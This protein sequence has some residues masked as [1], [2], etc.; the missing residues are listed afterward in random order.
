[1]EPKILING[2]EINDL[3]ELPESVRNLLADGNNNQIPD[4]AENPFAMFSK[5]GD[6]K[7]LTQNMGPILQ[8]LQGLQGGKMPQQQ[9]TFNGKEY[10]NWNEI[11]ESE[12]QAIKAKFQQM[13]HLTPT[14]V[15]QAQ[16]ETVSQAAQ[17][18]S[19]GTPQR[20]TSEIPGTTSPAIQEK[21]DKNRIAIFILAALAIGGW[22]L[23]EYMSK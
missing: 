21:Q 5:L 10:K 18:Q 9:I 13:K 4:I 8:Q 12:K 7:H 20:T 3:N 22:I 23:Y 19:M 11:P 17:T 16:S 1:M 14:Q 6:I 2:K 15:T